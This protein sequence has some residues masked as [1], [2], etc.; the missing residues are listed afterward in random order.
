[1]SDD[2]D[3][4]FDDLLAR[5]A[6]SKRKRPARLSPF[7]PGSD[8]W[9][10]WAWARRVGARVEQDSETH[11]W[12]RLV[13]CPSP[14]DEIALVRI[15]QKHPTLAA[16]IN[17]VFGETFGAFRAWQSNPN[18][19]ACGTFQHHLCRLSVCLQYACEFLEVSDEWVVV[20]L[21]HI[22][23]HRKTVSD[24]AEDP[25]KPFIEKRPGRGKYAIRQSHLIDYL[26]ASQAKKYGV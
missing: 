15:E 22:E 12:E 25:D 5:M 11:E 24:H 16:N 18:G 23:K 6:S 9:R 7:E 14:E 26:R 2:N 8:E 21:S 1:M 20:P 17:R 13:F 3:S 19:N 4:V 10:L